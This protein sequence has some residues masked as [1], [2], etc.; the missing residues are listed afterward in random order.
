MTNTKEEI[1][2]DAALR[3][4]LQDLLDKEEG[5]E[6]QKDEDPCW[7]GYEQVGMKEQGG[8]KVPNCVPKDES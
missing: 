6:E 2:K 8:E 1:K 4:R 3:V 5:D 7:D